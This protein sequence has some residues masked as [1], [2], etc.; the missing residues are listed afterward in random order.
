MR[1][2]I[3]TITPLFFSKNEGLKKGREEGRSEREHEITKNLLLK[4]ID[5]D[6][7]VS[8]TGLSIEVVTAVKDELGL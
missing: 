3:F 8:S 4:S 7:V 5:V 6:T 2:F 1:N